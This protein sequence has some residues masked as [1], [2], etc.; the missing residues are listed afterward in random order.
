M[1]NEIKKIEIWDRE[2]PIEIIYDCFEGENITEIQKEALLAFIKHKEVLLDRAYKIIMKYCMEEHIEYFSIVSENVFTCVKPYALYI[3]R[4][5]AKKQVVGLLCD[6][7]PDREHGLA[8][9]IE[10]CKH[11][12]VGPQDIIL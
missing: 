2:L 4:S 5:V 11:I 6:F 1:N 8:I 12:K 9:Y 7:K 10:D 3:K